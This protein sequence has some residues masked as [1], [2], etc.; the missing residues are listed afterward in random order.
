MSQNMVTGQKIPE[1]ISQI[2]LSPAKIS[3]TKKL[4]GKS[5]NLQK[6]PITKMSLNIYLYEGYKI[7]IYNGG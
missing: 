3:H 7:D 2:K 1:K 5:I 6:Y 4:H